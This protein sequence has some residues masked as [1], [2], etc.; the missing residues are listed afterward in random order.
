MMDDPARQIM[1]DDRLQIAGRLYQ[2]FAAHDATAL[3]AVLAPLSPT[4]RTVR[5]GK[6][7]R[8]EHWFS[9]SCLLEQGGLECGSRS[10]D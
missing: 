1:P 10:N 4:R 9:E 7:Y 8:W 2:A 6:Q 5:V 3:L